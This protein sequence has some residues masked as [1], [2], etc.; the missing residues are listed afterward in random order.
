MFGKRSEVRDA[1][2]RYANI[3]SAYLLQRMES[4]DGLAILAT[5]LRANLDEAFTRRL[6]VVVDFPM[7]DAGA[8]AARC[9]TAA[10][11]PRIPRGTTW[12]WTSAP[13][14]RAV[15]RQHPLRGGDRGVPGRRR[16][17]GSPDGRPG[18]RRP[19]GIPKAGP[20]HRGCR[21]RSLPRPVVLIRLPFRADSAARS[22]SRQAAARR[23]GRARHSIRVTGGGRC[24]RM[25]ELRTSQRGGRRVLRESGL[26]RI[27][28]LV[29]ERCR[30][31]DATRFGGSPTAGD[32]VGGPVAAGAGRA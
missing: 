22:S 30:G 21:I 7:P 9:G 18:G 28:G 25:L 14:V 4:F 3:E 29:D 31:A 15:R 24:A 5:N 13:R 11:A 10:S 26:P 27:P 16:G 23:G 1:H 20:A 32:A 8:A 2:D 17:A 6:D 19:P 12:T